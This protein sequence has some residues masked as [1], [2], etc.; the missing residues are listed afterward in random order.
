MDVMVDTSRAGTFSGRVGVLF[1]T[2]VFGAGVGIVNG[3]LLARLLGPAAKGEYYLLILVPSTVMV[4]IQ[5]GLPQ[6]FGYFSARGQTL[7]MLGKSLVLT[8]VLSSA[9]FVGVL[10]LLPLLSDAFLHGIGLGLVLFAFLA[11]PLALSATFTSGIVMGRQA[12]RWYAAINTAYPIATTLLLVAIF[13]ALVL[14]RDIFGLWS[15]LG[16][17]RRRWPKWCRSA[18]SSRPSA[19]TRIPGASLAAKPSAFRS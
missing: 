1:G 12:V 2:Q 13:L 4:L 8:A 9:A 10:V 11:L 18:A 7:G 16:S 19:P 14:T 5:L 6:A 3:I 15:G 17:S